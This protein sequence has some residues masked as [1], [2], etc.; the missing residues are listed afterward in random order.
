MFL[1]ILETFNEYAGIA[2]VAVT[3]IAAILAGIR[4]VIKLHRK[5]SV[6]ITPVGVMND[7]PGSVTGMNRYEDALETDDRKENK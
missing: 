4:V 1:K 2:I 6:D 5:E 7:L 3:I